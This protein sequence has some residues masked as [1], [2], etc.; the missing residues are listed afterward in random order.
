ML[1]FFVLT[2][3]T[4]AVVLFERSVASRKTYGKPGN[5]FDGKRFF[6]PDMPRRVD[7]ESERRSVWVWMFTRPR[8]SW[9]HTPVTPVRPLERVHEGIQ[10]TYVNHATVLLQFNGLNVITDPVWSYRASPFPFMGP[11]RYADPG[12]TLDDLPPI[13]IVLLSHN[14]YDHMDL[15]TLRHIA[16]KDKPRIYTG[17]GNTAYLARKGIEGAIEMDWWDT[18]S[19]GAMLITAVPAQHFSARS[20]TDRNYT[21]WCGFVLE[22]GSDRLYF[23]GDTGFG[24][25]VERIAAKFGSFTL[26]L[27]PIGAYDPAWMMR[28]VHTNPDEALRMHDMLNIRTSVGIHHGTF[29]LTDEPQREPRERIERERRERDFRVL[30]NGGTVLLK[31][32]SSESS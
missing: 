10:V 1:T 5:H 32:R 27:I 23:A 6:N 13:D 29:R 25:F 15:A 18:R 22:V 11:A 3:M 30:E 26:G 9:T 17:L 8:S 31:A 7:D 19:D 4:I 28:P 14:H 20:V 2:F 16:Q 12:V 24:P 21:L